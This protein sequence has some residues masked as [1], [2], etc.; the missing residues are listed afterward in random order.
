MIDN[1]LSYNITSRSRIS[2]TTNNFNI[3]LD[4]PKDILEKI[5]YCSVTNISLPKS[6]YQIEKGFNTFQLI[7]DNINI[8]ILIEEGNYTKIQLYTVLSNKMTL[9]SLNGI[10]YTVVDE[11]TSYDTGKLKIQAT[12][13]LLNKGLLFND[14]DLFQPMGFIPNKIYSFTTEIVSDNIINLNS[15]DVILLHSNIV[16]SNNNDL[17]GGSNVLCS[18]YTSG[19]KNY[20]YIIKSYDLI[21]NMK[22]FINN[23]IFNFYL[24]NENSQDIDTHGIDFNFVLNF[25]TYTPNYKIYN[26]IDNLINYSLIKD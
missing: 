3:K 7:E 18:I 24:T 2:G 22:K 13:P 16:S 15:E 6:F 11:Q 5:N 4:I 25:F 23:S 21:Y 26:K 10:V 12:N 20:S 8:N 9:N 19:Q 14:N 1:L 17:T